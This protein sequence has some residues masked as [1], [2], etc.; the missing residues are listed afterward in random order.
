[1][2]CTNLLEPL[3]SRTSNHQ[4]DTNKFQQDADPIHT[5]EFVL[6]WIKWG[7]KPKTLDLRLKHVLPPSPLKICGVSKVRS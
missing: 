7:F 4:L 2:L 5:P 3:L 1:M 6:E